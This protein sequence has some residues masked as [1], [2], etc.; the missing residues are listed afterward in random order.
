MER[1][2][3]GDKRVRLNRALASAGICSRRKA[4]ELI[5]TRRV[6]INGAIVG[7]P[8]IRVS[9]E[10]KLEIDD[11]I[12]PPAPAKIYLLL[13][14]PGRIVCTAHDPQ[15]RKTVLDLLPP[16]YR[17]FRLY[18]VGRLDY[19]SEGLLLLTND[20]DFAYRLTHPRHEILKTYRVIIAG[21]VPDAAL[22]A[23]RSGMTLDDGKKLLPVKARKQV[24][25]DGNAMLTLTLRQGINR[26]IRRMCAR[27]NLTILKLVRIREGSLSLGNLLPGQIRELTRQE[28]GSIFQEVRPKQSL[29][30]SASS[31]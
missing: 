7:N 27:L 8:A 5:L 9:P 21:G 23:M 15:G 16:K 25:R 30:K 11:R 19:F 1:G 22:E 29:K 6:R 18:P 10:D 13:N 26:Q 20:G 12:I 17:A 4:D 31:S 14:K 3:C 28:A 24:L 2:D